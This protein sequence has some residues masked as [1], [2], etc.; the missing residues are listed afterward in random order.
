MKELK[1]KSPA[2][3]NV[4]IPQIYVGECENDE[5]ICLSQKLDEFLSEPMEDMCS[6]GEKKVT[7]CTRK[8]VRGRIGFLEIVRLNYSTGCKSNAMVDFSKYYTF[9][10]FLHLSTLRKYHLLIPPITF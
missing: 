3:S 7:N 4:S 8:N 6:K 10:F 2:I 5:R 9:I 1:S